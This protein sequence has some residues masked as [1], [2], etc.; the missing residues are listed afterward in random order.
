MSSESVNRPLPGESHLRVAHSIGEQ[1]MVSYFTE[2][3]RRILDLILRLS[4]GCGKETAYIPRQ[5]D[6]EIVGVG[7]GHIR[8]HLDWLINARVV[9]RDGAHYAFTRDFSHWRVSRALKY[10]PEKLAELVSLN[11]RNKEENLRKGKVVGNVEITEKVSE[12]L[13]KREESTYGKGNFSTPEL[14]SPIERLYKDIELPLSKDRG[15]PPSKKGTKTLRDS[16]TTNSGKPAGEFVGS[17]KEN[18]AEKVGESEDKGAAPETGKF[19]GASSAAKRPRRK[20]EVTAPEVPV[21]MARCRT[22]LGFGTSTDKDPVPNPGKEG[23]FIKRMLSRGFTADEIFECWREKTE[24]RG[25]Y[26]PM[27][28][29]NEDIG[30]PVLRKER[31]YERT[32]ANQKP[33]TK[34]LYAS[35]PVIHSGSDDTEDVPQMSGRV[36]DGGASVPGSGQEGGA[37]QGPLP[38]V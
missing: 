4:W 27:N 8:V 19:V 17:S 37:D 5:K 21:I 6:F 11:L 15:L 20:A 12:K 7:E 1:L 35:V 38:Q 24:A 30:Q 9:T 23:K 13:P 25:G 36:P 14:A 32:Q 16:G 28:Y 22:Y 29:V 10:T 3:Q 2:Q 34:S 26:C 18:T 33:A 31:P